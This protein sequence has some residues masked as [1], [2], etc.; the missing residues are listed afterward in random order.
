MK[1]RISNNM[2][3]RRLALFPYRGKEIACYYCII[4]S[5]KANI[6]Q[7]LNKQH[8]RINKD[9]RIATSTERQVGKAWA[10]IQRRLRIFLTGQTSLSLKRID[11]TIAYFAGKRGQSEQI[12]T[13]LCKDLI[14]SLLL[15]S[16]I[17]MPHATFLLS[18]LFFALFRHCSRTRWAD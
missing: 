11:W 15:I 17:I 9:V 14:R 2:I 16:H 8:K 12:E 5:D 18:P 7:Q 6:N 13:D 1:I 10:P 4:P 3:F